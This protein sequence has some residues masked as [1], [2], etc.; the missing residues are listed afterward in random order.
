V[1]DI[2][3]GGVHKC[4]TSALHAYLVRHAEIQGGIRRE[5]HFFDRP[6]IDWSNPD[7]SSY[8]SMFPG[9]HARLRVDSSPS[10]IYLP[11]CLERLR[12]FN[13]DVRLIFIFRDPIERAWSHWNMATYNRRETMSFDEA[14]SAEAARLEVLSPIEGKSVAYVDRGRYG[15]QVARALSVFPREQILFLESASLKSRPESVLTQILEFLSLP[16]YC[17]A[18]PILANDGARTGRLMSMR[19]ETR[20]FIRD[21]LIDD[22]LLFTRLS[23]IDTRR[24]SIFSET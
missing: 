20:S 21:T 4:G 17:D 6:D 24:W 7:Y 3:I 10:Y 18:T 11:E 23:R 16:P 2:V 22:T 5:L 1:A 13:R 15:E 14:I 19:P 12:R 9:K 8:L